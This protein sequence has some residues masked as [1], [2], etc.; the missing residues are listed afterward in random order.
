KSPESATR[1]GFYRRLRFLLIAGILL[2]SAVLRADNLQKQ[3]GCPICNIEYTAFLT[4][5]S[6]VGLCL[7]GRPADGRTEPLAE[8]PLCRGVFADTTFSQAEIALLKK[9]IWS[10]DFQA[11]R[12]A[13]PA[14]RYAVLLEHLD[15]G[16]YETAMAWQ[17]ASWAAENNP[18]QQKTCR[19]KSFE[20]FRQAL[21]EKSA[22]YDPA[23]VFVI[24]LKIAELQRQMQNFS[25]AEQTL[26]KIST[27]PEFKSG[28]YPMIIRHCRKLVADR[29]SLP[30]VLPT[31]NKLHAAIDRGDLS[32]AT[33]LASESHDLLAEIDSAGRTP[34]LHAI[35]RKDAALIDCLISAGA[36]LSQAG[37]DG[38]TPLHQ[39]VLSGD[40]SIFAKI[41]AKTG[42]PD[43][44]NRE[45]NTPLFLAV[46]ERKPAMVNALLEAGA[47]FNRRD[48]RGNSLLHLLSPWKSYGGTPILEKL[49]SRMHEVDIRNFDDYTPLHLAAIEGNTLAMR[50]LMQAGANLDARLPDGSTALFFCKPQISGSLLGMGANRTL[51][52]NAGHTAIV[53]AR[54]T[55]D[56]ERI[57]YLKRTG[58]FGT[59][60]RKHYLKNHETTICNA[61][62]AAA[63]DDIIDIVKKYPEE[64]HHQDTELSE[65]PLHKAAALGNLKIM[66]LLIDLG[67][68]VNATNEFMRTPLHYAASR[69]DLDAVKLLLKAGA[70][71]QSVDF[72]GSTPLH[73]AARHRQVYIYLL[74]LDASDTTRDNDGQ[75]A[76]DLFNAR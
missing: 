57:K 48:S 44:V 21:I 17:R 11:W 58:R 55:G 34:L 39:A 52:N 46:L 49:A 69:G 9:F 4:A 41:L 19:E 66:Q 26:D 29:N 28:W 38:N 71:L 36:N 51:T 20:F 31:G 35:N 74:E 15:R 5:T 3:V 75:T 40:Q 27:A 70:N 6:S 47:D 42:N 32:E 22:S 1:A 24:S 7:D 25:E 60:P 2:F 62:Q 12:D 43:P 18:E 45:G 23:R 16:S 53:H 76:A 68:A 59:R 37:I 14:S 67:A 64:L 63:F 30:S 65:T 61:V 13:M 56:S 50:I 8:C 10:G 73:D 72:R 33:R 54:V